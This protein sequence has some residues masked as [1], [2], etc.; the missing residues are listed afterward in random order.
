MENIVLNSE[1]RKALIAAAQKAQERAYAPYSRYRV[2]AA[3]LCADGRIVTGCNIENASYGATVCAERVALW[4]AVSEGQRAFVAL[5]LVADPAAALEPGAKETGGSAFYPSPCGLCRQTL[6][7]FCAA[8]FPVVMA[9][10]ESDYRVMTL[11]ELL[12]ESFGPAFLG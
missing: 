8:D 11:G 4:K 1:R 10:G 6:R 7:E 3:L 5:A 9:R 2:G 12:P